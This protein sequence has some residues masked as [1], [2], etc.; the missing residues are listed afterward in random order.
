MGRGAV[1]ARGYE[2]DEGVK[3]LKERLRKLELSVARNKPASG[4]SVTD[5]G[6]FFGGPGAGLTIEDVM[7]LI[8][9]GL[10]PGAFLTVI[11]GGGGTVY[12]MGALGATET[13]GLGL[14]NY[15]WGT[16]DQACTIGF[17]GWTA[18]RDCQITVELTND[19]G[20]DATW[21]GVTWI[22]GTA[23]NPDTTAGTVAHYVFLSRDGGSTI[24]GAQVG[25][26]GSGAL[27][28]QLL[29][30]NAA[31]GST[32]ALDCDVA[33][34]FDLTLTANLTYTITN[35]PASGIARTIYVIFR[36]G[37]SGSYTVTHPAA[38][39]WQ[40]STDGT[41]GGSAPT[42]W[43]VVGAVNIIEL[44]T[45]DGGVTWGGADH[46]GG[47]GGSTTLAALTDVS[48]ASLANADRLRYS[49]T[50]SKWHNS[51]LVWTPLT[52]FDGTNWVLLTDGSGNPIMAEA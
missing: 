45:F 29:F 4:V 42:L 7:A 44:T 23:P 27:T 34:V 36:Q 40:D 35:P 12:P 10:S 37:G 24:Y 49:T 30:T 52:T 3:A 9:A 48:L 22:G 32:E 18:G 46:S 47:A 21:T 41:G 20:F 50:D 51:A 33:N 39:D 15:H 26:A 28:S 6:G 25:S 17:T 8:G 11:L 14:G 13:I 43:T 19:G 2:L 5:G 31:A 16:L 1:T 38:V